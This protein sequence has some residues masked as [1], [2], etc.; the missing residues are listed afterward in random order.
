[1][2][3][4]KLGTALL[5][6]WAFTQPPTANQPSSLPPDVVQSLLK[7]GER[8]IAVAQSGV[9]CEEQKRSE[10]ARLA[11]I[12]KEQL[13]VNTRLAGLEKQMALQ[14]NEASR[15]P[16]NS[17]EIVRI[18]AEN[19]ETRRNIV[20]TRSYL[21]QLSRDE[22]DAAARLNTHDACVLAAHK[23][24]AALRGGDSR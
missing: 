4:S 22:S 6:F 24:L 9:L 10:Q 13:E 19:D 15:T 14:R 20:T 3:E 16:A 23:Q 2:P 8:V 12:R 5:L 21:Q 11:A 17:P 7:A 1:M 18:R